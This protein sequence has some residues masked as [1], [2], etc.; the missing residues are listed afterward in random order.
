LEDLKA[1][2]APVIELENIE[3]VDIEDLETRSAP[4]IQHEE[5]AA[6]DL[7]DLE[8]RSPTL[9]H[10]QDITAEDLEETSPGGPHEERRSTQDRDFADA[11]VKQRRVLSEPERTVVRDAIKRF[12]SENPRKW[13]DACRDELEIAHNIRI[14]SSSLSTKKFRDK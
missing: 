11:N 12:S 1:R 13:V 4:L 5:I 3:A 2:T 7:E 8:F 6:V 9:I 14:G 10:L